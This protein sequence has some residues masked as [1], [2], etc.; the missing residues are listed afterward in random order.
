[1]RADRGECVYVAE[2]RDEVGYEVTRASAYA[3]TATAFTAFAYQGTRGSRPAKYN[4]TTSRLIE[5]A[6]RFSFSSIDGRPRG[7]RLPECSILATISF[8]GLKPPGG[9]RANG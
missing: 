8:G 2:N 9:G 1:M 6:H 5:R 3:T 4:A 7:L